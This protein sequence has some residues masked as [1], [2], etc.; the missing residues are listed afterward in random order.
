M[1]KS[2]STITTYNLL[3]EFY[4][5]EYSLRLSNP[6]TKIVVLCDDISYESIK[7]LGK[8]N[9]ILI[10]DLKNINYAELKTRG[11]S[12]LE[13]MLKKGDVI[14]KAVELFGETL[15][16]DTDIVFLNKFTE[17][18]KTE[19]CLSQHLMFEH[20][21][22][23]YGKYNGGYFYVNNV[24]F[25][26]WFK[27][28]TYEKSTFYE[29]GTLNFVEEDFI[30]SFFDINH[31]YGWWRLYQCS[32]TQERYKKFGYGD[33]VYYDKKPLISIHAHFVSDG[34]KDI[35]NDKFVDIIMKLLSVSKKNEHKLLFEYITKIKNGFNPI[36]PKVILPH[37]SIAGHCGDTFRELITMWA[38]KD[39]CDIEYST[40]NNHVWLNSIG[41]ILLYDR[42]TLEWL[43]N[44]KYRFALFGNPV[45][46][47][48]NSSSWIFWG[49]RPKLMEEVRNL[50][51]KNWSERNIESIFLGKVENNVQLGRRTNYDWTGSVE[52]FEMPIRGEYKYTQKEYLEI[53]SRSKF[54]LGLSGYGLKCN[55]EIEYLC[56]GVV[57]IVANDVDLTFYNQLEEGKH[58]L[59]VNTPEEVK[60]LISTITEEK[61][62]EMSKAGLQWYEENC[63]T[64]GSFIT[65]MKILNNK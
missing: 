33:N 56:L 42:P 6:D 29:Q 65:T 54:G 30:T 51:I 12:W 43:G 41:D 57:P 19:M 52:V 50:G 48:Q 17:D 15:F 40:N 44:E 3:K 27:K 14:D 22:A 4:I 61:W 37:P 7:K 25:S 63:S 10:N 60:P 59:R 8:N 31:N 13:F 24:K 55:R 35:N 62:N 46:D 53:I 9:I 39:L 32:E 64:I 58:Y 47:F 34:Y 38:D 20:D 18:I 36:K 1:L 11:N 2:V 28:T 21:E 26:D 49:R 5:L 45:V 23:K 16:V